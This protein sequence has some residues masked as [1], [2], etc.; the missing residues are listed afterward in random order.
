MVLLSSYRINRP[1]ATL[2]Q[3]IFS[4]PMAG[5]FPWRPG[6]LYLSVCT[7]TARL[8]LTSAIGPLGLTPV[9]VLVLL[10]VH[11]HAC[12]TIHVHVVYIIQV[13]VVQYMYMYYVHFHRQ[14]TC[15]SGVRVL[16]A[17]SVCICH[18]HVA[19]HFS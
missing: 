1:S 10:H 8:T 5:T 19:A 6:Q 4:A 14:S 18:V 9:L 7:L 17:L 15:L 11:V 13:H 2:S 3:P 12:C 16:F